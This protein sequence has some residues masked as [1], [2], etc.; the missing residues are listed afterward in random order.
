MKQMLIR[1][2]KIS[3]L[4]SFG[5][6]GIDSPMRPLKAL[7]GEGWETSAISA[8]PCSRM[9]KKNASSAKVEDLGGLFG[10]EG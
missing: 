7:I 4:L 10:P 2:L 3:R 6:D 8:V 5:P 9:N 1:T